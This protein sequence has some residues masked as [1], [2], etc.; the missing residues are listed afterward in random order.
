[1]NKNF[2]EDF[3]EEWRRLKKFNK[4]FNRVKSDLG[5]VTKSEAAAMNNTQDSSS[6]N[7]NQNKNKNNKG[8][9]NRDS[10]NKK[11]KWNNSWSENDWSSDKKSKWNKYDGYGN[12][13]EYKGKKDKSKKK[14]SHKKVLKGSEHDG[15]S[16]E[17]KGV[18]GKWCFKHLLGACERKSGITC[19]SDSSRSHADKG[20]ISAKD[21]ATIQDKYPKLFANKKFDELTFP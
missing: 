7:S 15:D 13:N 6:S 5:L 17:N 9:N 4:T 1:M 14:K 12:D 20:D 10:K 21:Y 11:D 2:L 16:K 8:N 18:I 3:K 19:P